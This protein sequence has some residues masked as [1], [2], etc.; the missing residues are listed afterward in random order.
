M[1]VWDI[2]KAEQVYLAKGAKPNRVGL[3]DM[4]W[5]TA[6]ALRPGSE[7]KQ[8]LVGTGQ[9]KVRLHDMGQRRPVLSVDFGEAKITALAPQSD[10]AH[11][12]CCSPFK[13]LV[14]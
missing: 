12:L 4:V 1:S 3:M 9:H 14:Q 13:N 5:N 10:G 6:V 8:I 11:P 2:E 7:G